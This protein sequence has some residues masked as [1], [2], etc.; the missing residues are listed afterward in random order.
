MITAVHP[1]ASSIAA[2]DLVNLLTRY[3]LSKDK[4]QGT[5]ASIVQDCLSNLPIAIS[6]DSVMG[7]KNASA[8]LAYANIKTA[9]ENHRIIR[10][11][12]HD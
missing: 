7:E 5:F 10:S 1:I 11:A 2:N 4:I 6:H 3:G 12:L 8:D 9:V